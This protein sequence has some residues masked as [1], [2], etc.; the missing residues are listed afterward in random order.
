MGVR[1]RANSLNFR[2]LSVLRGTYPLPIKP[3]VVMAADG[4]GEIASIGDGVSRVKVGERVAGTWNAYEAEWIA[5]GAAATATD[6]ER[7]AASYCE[8]A[9][10]ADMP[11][12]GVC[13]LVFNKPQIR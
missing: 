4:A 5:R 8:F 6:P 7:M 13:G 12:V 10:W 3:D 11:G 2:E 9:S 1:V